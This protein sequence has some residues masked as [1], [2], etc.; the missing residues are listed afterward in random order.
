[1]LYNPYIYKI[2]SFFYSSIIQ[3]ILRGMFKIIETKQKFLYLFIFQHIQNNE[4]Q[5]QN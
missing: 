4:K 2:N 3:S 1:M 5:K